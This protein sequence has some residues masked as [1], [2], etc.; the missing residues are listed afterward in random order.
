MSLHF[1]VVLQRKNRASNQTKEPRILLC[2]LWC[3]IQYITNNE[4]SS[5]TERCLQCRWPVLRNWLRGRH[6]FYSKNETNSEYEYDYDYSYS[7]VFFLFFV[8]FSLLSRI[9][10]IVQPKPTHTHAYTYRSSLHDSHICICIDD[11]C[12][13][14]YI[15]THI[16]VYKLYCRYFRY[17]RVQQLC[18]YVCTHFPTHTVGIL[19]IP[20]GDIVFLLALGEFLMFLFTNSRTLAY[21]YTYACL[22]VWAHINK[23]DAWAVT[24]V[25][26]PPVCR[27]VVN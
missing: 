7:Q 8:S 20:I 10:H 12:R 16:Y 9:Y 2:A 27:Y 11:L 18:T 13:C 19:Q 26:R 21:V 4:L 24:V 15:W 23:C 5:N 22:C 14:T 25:R 1:V 17:W 3:D 6:T